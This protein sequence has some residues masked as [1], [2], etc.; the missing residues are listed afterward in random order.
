MVKTKFSRL[1]WEH[2]DANVAASAEAYLNRVAVPEEM[3]GAVAFMASDDSSFMTG[4][5]MV[6][7]GGVRA[8][9]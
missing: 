7:G 8:R 2:E 4:E 3:G 1:L 6:L 5:T 9:L